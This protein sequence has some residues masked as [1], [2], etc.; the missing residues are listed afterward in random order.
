MKIDL[1]Q[2]E[3]A[4]EILRKNKLRNEKPQSKPCILSLILTFII[5]ILC[6]ALIYYI[7]TTNIKTATNADWYVIFMP[8]IYSPMLLIFFLYKGKLFCELRVFLI[9]LATSEMFT[10]TIMFK[11]LIIQQGLDFIFNYGILTTY[12]ILLLVHILLTCLEITIT[13]KTF[14]ANHPIYKP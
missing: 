9:T 10:I 14:I 11:N 12:V 5:G 6:S 3:K 4:R 7:H 1:E 8:Y 2:E 13:L